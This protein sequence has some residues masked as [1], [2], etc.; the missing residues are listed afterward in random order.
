MTYETPVGANMFAYCLNN[1]VN[2]IELVGNY[3][4]YIIK[5]INEQYIDE[6]Y[7]IINIDYVVYDTEASF[8]GDGG[9]SASEQIEYSVS[10]GIIHILNQQKGAALLAIPE[11]SCAVANTIM[12]RTQSL[13]PNSLEGRT[14]MGVGLE[15][16][17]HLV[18]FKLGIMT[19]KTDV[20]DIG[21]L[22]T[23]SYG[24]DYNAWWFEVFVQPNNALKN[25]R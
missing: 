9:V 11:I 1:P 19:M 10:E 7:I 5:S 16:F 13:Y 23:D 25:G 20:T 17:A 15:L 2:M 12:N 3:P 21:S 14:T 6:N 18:P 8:W 22:I 4:V 24:Y